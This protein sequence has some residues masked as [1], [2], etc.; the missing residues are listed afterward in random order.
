MAAEAPDSLKVVAARLLPCL[1]L[2]S[3]ND[4]DTTERIATLCRR[5]VTPYG[6][7]AA[8]CVWPRF[9]AQAR[10][11]LR[12]TD[13]RVATVV[14]FPTGN[15]GAAEVAAETRAAVA[16]GADEIDLVFPYVAYLAGARAAPRC[17][18]QTVRE[19]SGS[20]RCLKV[21]LETGRL[22]RP[23][24]IA[25]AARDAIAAGADFLKT[26]TGKVDPGATPDA[27]EV[28]LVVIR[29]HRRATGRSI[30]LKAAGGIRTVTQAGVYVDLVDRI[31]G[32]DLALPATFRIGASGLLDDISA[33]LG[34]A[35]AHAGTSG[36]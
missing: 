20:N 35:R 12:D 21:I 2:T 10:D 1:D 29:D 17:M 15:S 3:L 4:D 24:I 30:G 33:V 18:V 34:G 13:V 9:V 22:A 7:V 27:T 26:S 23:D 25:A 8:V 6:K 11:L 19:A 16:A 36:Y 31:I 14:N 28:L 5:A 32:P